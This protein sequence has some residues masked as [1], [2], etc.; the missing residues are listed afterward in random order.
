ML[1]CWCTI[2]TTISYIPICATTKAKLDLIYK[3]C[4]LYANHPNQPRHDLALIQLK[5]RS[6]S[7]Y[8]MFNQDSTRVE[9]HNSL[10]LNA[11]HIKRKMCRYSGSSWMSSY[12]RSINTFNGAPQIRYWSTMQ[13]HQHRLHGIYMCGDEISQCRYA[14]TTCATRE[15]TTSFCKSMILGKEVTTCAYIQPETNA[16]IRA[17]GARASLSLQ[18]P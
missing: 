6:T 17:G 13:Q 7:L 14:C 9:D 4:H 5:K 15:T 11:K 10:P 18:T 1:R 8:T 16:I 2:S 12:T 3:V